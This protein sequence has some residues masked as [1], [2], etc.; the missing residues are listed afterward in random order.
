MVTLFFK[1]FEKDNTVTGTWIGC[2]HAGIYGLRM[3]PSDK[4]CPKD[5]D[6]WQPTKFSY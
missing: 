5:Y 6:T 2:S 3:H 4:D 1:G